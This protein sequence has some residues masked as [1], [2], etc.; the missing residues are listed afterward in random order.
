MPMPEPRRMICYDEENRRFQVR[1]ASIAL[2]DN[3]L[4]RNS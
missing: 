2:R 4:V 3:D 1:A